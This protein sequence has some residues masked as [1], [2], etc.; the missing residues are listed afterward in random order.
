MEDFLNLTTKLHVIFIY[1]ALGVAIL[2]AYLMTR[3]EP[4]KKFLAILPLYYTILASLAFT[5][6]I[7]AFYIQNWLFIILMAV[8]WHLILITTIKSYKLTKKEKNLSKQS[9][10]KVQKKFYLDIA[11]YLIYMIVELI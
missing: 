11:I 9:L 3:Q 6:I 8:A 7:L 2:G 1:L 10:G 4:K 5:G